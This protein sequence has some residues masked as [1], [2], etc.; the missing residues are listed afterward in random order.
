MVS[1]IYQCL[2]LPGMGVEA[3]RGARP[4]CCHQVVVNLVTFVI[5]HL[6]IHSLVNAFELNSGFATSH[7]VVSVRYPI[8]Y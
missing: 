5:F 2:H 6:C 3:K 8:T 4:P 1:I 7:V